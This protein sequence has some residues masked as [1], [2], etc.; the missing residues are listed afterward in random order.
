MTD[1]YDPTF[2][3]GG[4]EWGPMPDGS[5]GGRVSATQ[6][7]VVLWCVWVLI[8]AAIDVLIRRIAIDHTWLRG[9]AFAAVLEIGRY[10][11]KIGL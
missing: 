3:S 5:Q 6:K 2:D 10:M 9:A 7:K 11:G 1:T 4:M 8:A